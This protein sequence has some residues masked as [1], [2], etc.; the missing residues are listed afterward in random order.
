MF[1]AA[2]HFYKTS[3]TSAIRYIARNIKFVEHENDFRT[4]WLTDVEG[5]V[6]I[7][8]ST[9]SQSASFTGQVRVTPIWDNNPIPSMCWLHYLLNSIL[10][11][12]HMFFL[13]LFFLNMKLSFIIDKSYF[14]LHIGSIWEWRGLW[15]CLDMIGYEEILLLW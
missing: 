9:S 7:R 14:F 15:K 3:L 5:T 6:K 2:K 12:Y 1:R 10:K 8:L 11:K 13:F 4:F